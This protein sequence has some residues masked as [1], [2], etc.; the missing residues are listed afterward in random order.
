M[1][2]KL[3]FQKTVSEDWLVAANKWKKIYKNIFEQW[4]TK[5]RKNRKKEAIADY[6]KV[7]I[8]IICFFV[9]FF[10][11]FLFSGYKYTAIKKGIFFG[12]KQM[13]KLRSKDSKS[14]NS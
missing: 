14:S 11:F 7:V 1:S 13:A 3:K 12:R 10:F 5:R 8:E 9:F 2:V 4:S 6:L